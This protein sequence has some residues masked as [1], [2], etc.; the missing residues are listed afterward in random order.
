[1]KTAEA[2][3]ILSEALEQEP[4]LRGAFIAS[5]E[6]SLVEQGVVTLPFQDETEMATRIFKR[7]IGEE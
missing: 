5:I 1:M 6:S 4:E 2:I 3:R 7:L